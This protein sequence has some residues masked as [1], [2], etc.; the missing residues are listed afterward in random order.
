MVSGSAVF[1]DYLQEEY[2]LVENRIITLSF[3]VSNKKLDIP[4]TYECVKNSSK[5]FKGAFYNVYEFRSKL[6]YLL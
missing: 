2:T 5:L 6:F 3:L 1:L 4:N